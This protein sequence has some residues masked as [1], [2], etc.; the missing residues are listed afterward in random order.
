MQNPRGFCPTQKP[1][2]FVMVRFFDTF[3]FLTIS[4][5]P[6]VLLLIFS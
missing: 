1:L 5:P 2:A 4:Y 3:P 6:S